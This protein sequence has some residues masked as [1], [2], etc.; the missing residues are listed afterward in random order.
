MLASGPMGRVVL[1]SLLNQTPGLM[2]FTLFRQGLQRYYTCSRAF[3]MTLEGFETL[4]GAIPEEYTEVDS[5]AKC[6]PR[7]LRLSPETGVYVAESMWEDQVRE[8]EILLAGK[9]TDGQLDFLVYGADGVLTDR[10]Q[11]PVI[12]GGQHL[13]TSSPY[14]CMS[15]HMNPEASEHIWGYD[16][17]V[18]TTGPCAR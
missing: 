18:P 13:V 9:R 16:T 7:R 10:S 8:T 2:D 17:L 5:A 14:T 4:Y 1:V 15:C 3:P 12:G 11:F 6:A